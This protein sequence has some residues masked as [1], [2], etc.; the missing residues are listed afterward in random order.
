MPQMISHDIDRFVPCTH[1]DLPSTLPA[2]ILYSSV[3]HCALSTTKLSV[4]NR[5]EPSDHCRLAKNGKALNPLSSISCE[6]LLQNPGLI[7]CLKVTSWSRRDGNRFL[8]DIPRCPLRDTEPVE[9]GC[10]CPC[11]LFQPCYRIELL[12]VGVSDCTYCHLDT[13]RRTSR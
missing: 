3:P 6:N 7:S 2:C 12:R 9:G 13:D 10:L 4:S 5:A 8:Q 11:S 1:H